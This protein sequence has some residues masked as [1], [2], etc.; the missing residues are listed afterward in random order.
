MLIA[1][2]L[3]LWLGMPPHQDGRTIHARPVEAAP[4]LAEAAPF[5]QLRVSGPFDAPAETILIYAYWDAPFGVANRQLQ[6]ALRRSVEGSDATSWA[7]TTTCAGMRQVIGELEDLEMP[8]INVPGAG[9]PDRLP[10]FSV[11]D[12]KSTSLRVTRTVWGEHALMADW[13]WLQ[14]NSGTPLGRWEERLSGIVSQCWDERPPADATLEE[15][16]GHR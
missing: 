16:P 15:A 1:S 10:D 7:V 13:L 8:R 3:A 4:L 6:Y 5:G 14:G 11:K 9:A 12:G 2:V